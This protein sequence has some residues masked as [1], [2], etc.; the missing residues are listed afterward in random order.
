MQQLE[1]SLKQGLLC[2][3]YLFWGSET[4]LLEQAVARIT[5]L[6]LPEGAAGSD[7]GRE[8]FRG[9]GDNVKEVVQA[10]NSPSFF[11]PR[12]LILVRGVT[13]FKPKKRK[14]GAEPLSGAEEEE[15]PGVEL[16]PLLDYL[17]DPNPATVLIMLSEG[18]VPKNSRVYKAVRDKGRAV[19][20]APLKGGAREQWLRNYCQAAGKK[21]DP[22]ALS[23]LCLMSGDSLAALKTEADKLLL[24]CAD[25]AR[26]TL[27]EAEAIASRGAAAGV[28]ELTDAAATRDAARAVDLLRRLLVQGE[29]PYN[30]LARLAGQFRNLL[31]VGDM[32][33]RGFS[34]GEIASQAGLA[35][36]VVQKS[37]AQARFYDMPRLSRALNILLSVEMEG[38]SGRVEVADGLELALMRIC[39]L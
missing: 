36:Y 20:F 5:E 26:I 7:W 27:A 30:L 35:P 23:Y 18:S 13:W 16:G 10:A 37:A 38:K 33:S 3:V 8:L 21:A 1:S 34:Q 32:L 22:A 9:D 24:Y 19:E 29:S 11:C 39:T 12:K 17:R 28:F 15:A 6:V 4:M 14:S 31:L 25:R 2:P